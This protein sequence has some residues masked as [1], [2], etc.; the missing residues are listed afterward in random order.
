VSSTGAFQQISTPRRTVVITVK[1]QTSP[2]ITPRV[3]STTIAGRNAW[4]TCPAAL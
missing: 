1:V 2:K 3:L 4:R